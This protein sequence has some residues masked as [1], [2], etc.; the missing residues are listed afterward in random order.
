[1]ICADQTELNILEVGIICTIDI[2]I[3]PSGTFGIANKGR[4]DNESKPSKGLCHD[5]LGELNL[6]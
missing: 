2:L 5:S 6:I 3:Q 4:C 1:M